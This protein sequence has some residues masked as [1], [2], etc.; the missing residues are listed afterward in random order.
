MTVD[1]DPNSLP[2][3]SGKLQSASKNLIL[4]DLEVASRQDVGTQLWRSAHYPII[5]AL[6]KQL[7]TKTREGEMIL[8]T[9]GCML[10]RGMLN[11]L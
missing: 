1:H 3:S 8:P 2:L 5:E 7:Q 4:L 9:S 11:P 10:G 6:R